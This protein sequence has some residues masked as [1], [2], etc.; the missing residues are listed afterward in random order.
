MVCQTYRSRIYNCQHTSERLTPSVQ[1][2]IRIRTKVKFFE[3]LPR[4]G[5]TSANEEEIEDLYCLLDRR[6]WRKTTGV[7]ARTA[8]V[9][10]LQHQGW[11]AGEVRKTRS[12]VVYRL[13]CFSKE[14]S[15]QTR[16]NIH[17]ILVGCVETNC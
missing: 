17:T 6:E 1:W 14:Y 12:Q 9:C 4:E 8:G 7:N 13:T 11:D 16:R 3:M 5:Y 15:F 2:P 10:E